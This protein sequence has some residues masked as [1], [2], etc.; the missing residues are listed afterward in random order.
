MKQD[1]I[2]SFG[3]LPELVIGPICS[4]RV[5]LLGPTAEDIV[6][7][8]RETGRNWRAEA[9]TEEEECIDATRRQTLRRKNLKAFQLLGRNLLLSETPVPRATSKTPTEYA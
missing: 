1:C 5:L 9:V 8:C 7:E 6:E 3:T 2:D 4:L